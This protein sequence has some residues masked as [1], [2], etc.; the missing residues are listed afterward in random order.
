MQELGRAPPSLDQF[1]KDRFVGTIEEVIDQINS[2][3]DLGISH[4][5][6]TVNS[7]NTRNAIEKINNGVRN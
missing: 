2:L 4:V 7:D 1:K 6:L 5:I 3:H